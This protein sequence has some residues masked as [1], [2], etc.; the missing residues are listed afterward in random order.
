[1]LRRDKVIEAGGFEDEFRRIYTDQVFYAKVC[2]KW[3]VF[4][5]GQSWFKYRKHQDSAVAVV[6]KRGQLQSARLTYLNWLERYLEKQEIENNEVRRA[7]NI[8]RWK[9][10]YP[11]L[12]RIMAHTKY[13]ALIAG[14]SL[15]SMARQQ[16]PAFVHRRLRTQR[17]NRVG[18]PR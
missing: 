14:E 4:V 9:C 17:K 16:L 8:A 15:R 5:A 10:H 11:K 7:L 3:P 6:K 13:R 18:E 1:M 2:L 12:F